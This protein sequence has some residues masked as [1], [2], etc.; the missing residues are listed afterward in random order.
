MSA[1]VK[2]R[3]FVIAAPLVTLA[4]PALSLTAT[5]CEG[6]NKSAPNA[7]ADGATTTSEAG[8]TG[9][10]DSGHGSIKAPMG[11]AGMRRQPWLSVPSATANILPNMG[12]PDRFEAEQK[13]RPANLKPNAEAIF[14]ALEKAGLAVV[15]KKQHLGQTFGARYC[16]G[17]RV[18]NGR[19]AGDLTM[20][21]LSVCEFINAEV[22]VMSRDYSIEALKMIPNRTVHAS[23]QTTLTVR[24]EQPLTPENEAAAAKAVEVYGAL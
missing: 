7:G 5:G 24:R 16:V 10:L 2:S 17:A 12:I 11:D 20:L 21:Q 8:A 6:C 23:K 15:D 22:A 1:A 13:A 9:G 3:L 4:L 14:A 19:D 18:V